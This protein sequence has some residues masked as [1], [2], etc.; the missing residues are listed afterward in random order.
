MA[1]AKY[2]DIALHLDRIKFLFHEQE[3]DPL[4]KRYD[5]A[6]G[7]DQIITELKPKSLQQPI[8]ATI[9]L[10]REQISGDSESVSSDVVRGYC[11]VQIHRINQDMAS[12]RWQ[13]IKALQTGVLFLAACLLLSAFFSGLEALPEFLRTFLSEGFLIAGWV[14]LWHPTELLLYEWWPLWRDK[15]LY[16]RIRDME[17]IIAPEA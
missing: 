10:P 14:S 5:S 13:G 17:I 15:K 12:L 4:N 3:F 6:S 8:R 2:Y 7:L 1:A 9:F 16:N 11:D